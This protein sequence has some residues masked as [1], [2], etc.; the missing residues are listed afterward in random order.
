MACLLLAEDIFGRERGIGV[1]EIGVE[2]MAR[3]GVFGSGNG[4]GGGVGVRTVKCE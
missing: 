1:G 3:E 4:G 2:W